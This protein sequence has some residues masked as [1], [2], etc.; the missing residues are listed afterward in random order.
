MADERDV[1]PEREDLM[2][3]LG[4]GAEK[5]AGQGPRE[6]SDEELDAVSGGVTG[7]ATSLPPGLF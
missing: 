4:A 5:D 6:L 7:P 3:G 1:A 2:E